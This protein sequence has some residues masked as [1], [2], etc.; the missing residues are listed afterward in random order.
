MELEAV[1]I[2]ADPERLNQIFNNL[3]SN[4]L[5]FTNEGFVQ[6]EYTQKGA[7]LQFEI[8]DT[9]IGI[10]ADFHAKIFDRFSQVEAS[11]S[12]QYG[13]NGLGLAI[14]KN[15]VELMGGKIWLESE[16]AVGTSFYFTLPLKDAESVIH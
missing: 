13:G 15:L 1:R 7:M 5:K 4:A 2:M 9:G 14:T 10:P 3:L 16:P 11:N 8:K 12:R 6:L